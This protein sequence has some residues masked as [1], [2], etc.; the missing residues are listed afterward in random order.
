MKLLRKTKNSIIGYAFISPTAIGLFVVIFLPILFSL[1]MSFHQ[2]EVITP[3]VF[4]GL[5]N[6]EKMLG[7]H[8]VEETAAELKASNQSWMFWKAVEPNDPLFWQYLKNTLYFVLSVPFVM[9]VALITAVAMNQEGLRGKVIF[10]TVFFMPVVTSIIAAGLLWRWMLNGEYGTIN[11]ILAWF[12]IDG[13]NWLGDEQWAKPAV[14]IFRIW[15]RCGYNMLIYLAGLQG[16]SP[17]LYEA[18]DIDGARGLHKLRYI[19]MPLLAPT[20]FFVM[21]LET[22]V[23]FQIFDLIYVMTPQGGPGGSTTPL[24][25]YM[26]SNAFE[27]FRMGYASAI[28]WIVFLII[29]IL[30]VIQWR[31]RKKWVYI[32]E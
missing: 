29:F 9:A 24:T 22:I 8:T 14:F 31:L 11:T 15:N 20:H 19:T 28:A 32:E 26:F 4:K 7:F 21:V 16:I 2:W 18:A 6:Y 17:T 25:Y 27:W 30:T 23:V 13:P 1:Y 10:R 5:Q 12:G 3:P